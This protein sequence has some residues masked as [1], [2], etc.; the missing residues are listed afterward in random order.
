MRL[1]VSALSQEKVLIVPDKDADGLAAG[2]I[3][4]RTLVALGLPP[5]S[6][7]THLVK[8]GSN[9]HDE[10]ERLSMKEKK[11]RYVIVVDQGSR[12]GPSIIDA[13]QAK[14]LIIDHHLSDESPE[15]SM[16]K[17]FSLSRRK[18]KL[19]QQRSF[20]PAIILPLRLP[21]YLH[22]RSASPCIPL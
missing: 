5:S 16:V 11:P 2:V 6:I 19:S 18:P 22:T 17:E 4:H 13:P 21:P 15:N 3:V 9:I 12:P 1:P 14:Y 10:A 20:L 8:K 7:E